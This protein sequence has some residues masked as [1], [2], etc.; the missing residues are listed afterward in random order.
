MPVPCVRVETSKT[1]NGVPIET[2]LEQF[3]NGKS[4]VLTEQ[5]T[6]PTVFDPTDTEALDESYRA[7]AWRFDPDDHA[8][9]NLLDGL[10]AAL[11]GAAKWYR[12]RFHTCEH[13]LPSE[14]RTGCSWDE[15]MTR[16]GGPVPPELA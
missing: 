4:R 8:A 11:S 1:S 9:A 10:E 2:I 14:D 3:Q 13:D 5:E 15:S 6:P 12:I 7:A 16:E